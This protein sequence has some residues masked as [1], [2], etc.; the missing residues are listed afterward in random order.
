[1]SYRPK[2]DIFYE[3]IFMKIFC[4]VYA[5]RSECARNDG[6][7]KPFLKLYSIEIPSSLPFSVQRILLYNLLDIQGRS[8]YTSPVK[9]EYFIK[10]TNLN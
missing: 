3:F 7:V 5:E 1:M 4:G 2:G 6:R 9:K 10:Q 8:S